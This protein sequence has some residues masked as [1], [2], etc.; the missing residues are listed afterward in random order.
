MGITLSELTTAVQQDAAIRRVQRLQ[1][2]G[3]AGDK[4]YPPTYPGARS[5]DP[6]QHI[7]EDRR[8]DGADV[9]CVLLDSVQSQANRLEEGLL[10]AMDQGRARIPHV[11]VD[12]METSDATGLA[13]LGRITSL[14]A[15]HRI[16]DAIIR[17]SQLDGVRFTDTPQYRELI[18]AK[19]AHALQV[20]RL[21]PTSL[22]FGAWN[23]TGEGGGLGAKFTRCIVSEVVGI[24]AA[25]GRAGA[26]RIDP[27]GV[28]AVVK[29]VGDSM[30]YHVAQGTEGKKAVRPSE[31][32]HSNIISTP[33]ERGVTVDYA[34]HTS[35]ITCAGLRR[36]AF[37]GT[38]DSAPGRT[39]LAA[40]GLLALKEQD[41]AGYA[42][43]SRC[44]LVAEAL[45]PFQVVHPDGGT[46]NFEL[47]ADEAV[48]LLHE[49][50]EEARVAG[51]PWEEAPLRLVPQPRLV[52]L[53]VKSRELTLAGQTE[54]DDQNA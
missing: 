35:V 30:N 54:A 3:G 10:R 36:L 19:P 29:V 28:R 45:R 1:P 32:N 42:L 23:S 8:L 14:D 31:I 6:A 44:D 53:V 40:L 16:F 4:L 11:S 18:L 27:L 12:F 49:A 15:P 9:R 43:R 48:Q 52:E 20:F 47:R 5:N 33:V 37:P 13:D 39:V 21:S 34:L 17:D 22:L 2:A 50:V 51:Y 25:H 41:A 38:G 46:S 26:V 7:F 24:G